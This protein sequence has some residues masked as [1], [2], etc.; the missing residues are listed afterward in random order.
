MVCLDR[1]RFYLSSDGQE[2]EPLVVQQ[3]VKKGENI[4]SVVAHKQQGCFKSGTCTC[5]PDSF[6]TYSAQCFVL[7]M[8]IF[9]LSLLLTRG[10]AVATGYSSLLV[11][12]F[13]CLSVCLSAILSLLTWLPQR[14]I[15][16]MDSLHTTSY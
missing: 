13:V 15:Y 2:A 7:I 3:K 8:T 1:L 5:M 16:S 12:L 6:S 14:C 4:S 10:R 9:T 11:C